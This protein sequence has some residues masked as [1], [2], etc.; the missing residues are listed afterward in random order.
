MNP[1]QFER[2]ID[3]SVRR[4]PS[5]SGVSPEV[6]ARN[7]MEGVFRDALRHGPLPETWMALGRRRGIDMDNL[8][9]LPETEWEAYCRKRKAEEA[10][11]ESQE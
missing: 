7:W 5:K 9:P 4:F 3:D 1:K 6:E 2:F 8:T 11:K 10:A